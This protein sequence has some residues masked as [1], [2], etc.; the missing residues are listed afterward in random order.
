MK[1]SEIIPT[2]PYLIG[3]SRKRKHCKSADKGGFTWELGNLVFGNP[4]DQI[5]KAA[6]IRKASNE[7]HR[8]KERT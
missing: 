7:K 8:K 4:L 5:G 1:L 3:R 6:K 2:A